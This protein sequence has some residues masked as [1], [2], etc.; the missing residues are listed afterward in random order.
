MYIYIY[1]ECIY[2]YMLLLYVI[3]NIYYK[4]VIYYM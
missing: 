1:N 3:Y 4:Y 2:T